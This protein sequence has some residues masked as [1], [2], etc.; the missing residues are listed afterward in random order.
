M[1]ATSRAAVRLGR[2]VQTGVLLVFALLVFGWIQVPSAAPIAPAAVLLAYAGFAH[3]G[4]RITAQRNP[5]TPG[6]TAAFGVLSAA[7]LVPSLLVEYFGRTL[8]NAVIVAIVVALWFCS[9]VL[10]AKLTGR[11]RDAVVSSTLSA[12]IGSLANVGSILVSYYALRGSALQDVYF[13]TEGT[14]EDFARSGASDFST[15]IMGDLF[16]GA[17]FHLLL[18]GLIGAFLGLIGGVVTVVV[19]RVAKRRNG[20]VPLTRLHP[21][22]SRPRAGPKE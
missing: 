22:A 1:L 21:T 18:G 6:V 5:R 17:F 20:E 14:Y 10:A 11:I 16:G 19:T 4:V 15:Y 7:V 13:R 3:L 12:Q 9:G 8:N 2:G